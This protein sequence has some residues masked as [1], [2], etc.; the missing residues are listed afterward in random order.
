[1]TPL[2]K[3]KKKKK[4][5]VKEKERKTGLSKQIILKIHPLTNRQ[6]DRR[7]HPDPIH[8]RRSPQLNLVALRIAF[9]P[10]PVHLDMVLRPRRQARY[11]IGYLEAAVGG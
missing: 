2:R 6:H 4:K 10:S 9:S 7:L 8:R 11:K 1:M 3:K 5:E